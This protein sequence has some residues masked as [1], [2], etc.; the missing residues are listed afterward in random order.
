MRP[1]GFV[2]QPGFK[3]FTGEQ[4]TAVTQHDRQEVQLLLSC[5]ADPYAYSKYETFS[6]YDD[7]IFTA[8]YRIVCSRAS[9]SIRQ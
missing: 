4:A 1:E 7:A 8:F 3:I 2:W 5:L 9:Y 6:I